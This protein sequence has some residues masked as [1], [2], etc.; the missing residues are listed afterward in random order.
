LKRRKRKHPAKRTVKAVQASAAPAVLPLD[1]ACLTEREAADLLAAV[2]A[3]LDAAEQ[4][5]LRPRLRHDAV[6][7]EDGY[8]LRIA[9]QWV[10]RTRMLTEFP[11]GQHGSNEEA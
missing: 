11:T 9:G 7:T 4:S 5:G 10:S 8:V 2:A 6:L 1:P 3:A